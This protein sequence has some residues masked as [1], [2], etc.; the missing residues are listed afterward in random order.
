M[1]RN[2]KYMHY[3]DEHLTLEGLH[4]IWRRIHSR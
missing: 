3:L 4:L 2:S 1:M